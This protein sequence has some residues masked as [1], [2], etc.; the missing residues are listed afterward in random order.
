MS[1]VMRVLYDREF[2]AI[3]SI[4]VEETKI[5]GNLTQ[6]EAQI[7][8][9]RGACASDQMLLSVGAQLLW[10]GWTT[11]THRQLNTELA[12]VMAKKL[13]ALDRVRVA[14]GRQRAVEMMMSAE[15][16]AL[17]DRRIKQRD[18]DLLSLG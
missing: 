13:V 10:Q 4:L 1:E 9:N 17:K 14:F 15:R 12:Q 6:L 3:S 16:R 8:R 18:A 2:R 5:R 11:R 7:S